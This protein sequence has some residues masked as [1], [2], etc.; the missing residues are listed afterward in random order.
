MKILCDTKNRTCL[1]NLYAFL[2]IFLIAS[3]YGYWFASNQLQAISSDAILSM[4]PKKY[5]IISVFRC[6]L[7]II[8]LFV[9]SAVA[10]TSISRG[11]LNYFV[12]A[13][14]YTP[15]VLVYFNYS[16]Y[17]IVCGIIFLQFILLISTFRSNDYRWLFSTCLVDLTILCVI[18]LLHLFIT[19][20]F[21]PLYWNVSWHTSAGAEE[22]PMVA[23]IFKGFV[24]TK[25]FAF[26][27][28][29]YS[30]WAGVLNPPI[31][32]NSPFLE[33]LTFIFDLPSISIEAFHIV[34][35]AVDFTL[36]IIG[37]FGFYLFLK[38]A[39]KLR[40]V[41]A[42]IGG[43]LFF[44][45]PFMATMMTEDGGIFLSS[46]AIFPYALLLI[47]LAFEKNNYSLAIW[48]GVAIAAQF[49]FASPH[50]EGV[51]YSLLFYGVF[52]AGLFLLAKHLT[53]RSKI[54]LSITSVFVFFMLAAFVVLP[55][56]VDQFNGNMHAY[57]HMKDMQ[58]ISF[59]SFG[60]YGILLVIYSLISVALLKKQH[61][62]TDVHISSMILALFLLLLM[63]LT[64]QVRFNNILINF[65]HIGL[66]VGHAWRIGIFF[67][68]MV[69]VMAIISMD[70]LTQECLAVI[71]RKF[72]RTAKDIT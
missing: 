27:T 40:S 67:C 9:I 35:L 33:M 15:L 7:S 12:V 51:I 55:I 63:V 43:C 68:M 13:L 52:T 45:S 57:A 31:T 44:F 24:H 38:Y 1:F 37:S 21:S 39:F 48:A 17:W 3:A 65:L 22:I 28:M 11:K 19:T 66:N 23:S 50:P 4:Y 29:D 64:T 41:F 42:C 32:L 56:L 10:L 62:I 6:S 69:F 26:S 34:L 53:W 20:G 49:F 8:A 46:Y 16:M 61:R 70:T 72:S 30:E 60:A 71:S 36:I 18:F 58:P 25:Q 2:S 59:R 47:S 54:M 5:F 14:T